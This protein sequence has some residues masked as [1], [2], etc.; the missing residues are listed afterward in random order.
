M[1]NIYMAVIAAFVLF[2][3]GNGWAADKAVSTP[4][5]VMQAVQTQIGVCKAEKAK[6]ARQC[7]ASLYGQILS[8]QFVNWQQGSAVSLRLADVGFQT[9]SSAT[10][11]FQTL[12]WQGQML[13]QEF[14]DL[15]L[16][17]NAVKRALR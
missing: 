5:P 6:V 9:R 13:N 2:F 14:T 10:P 11:E 1:K 8:R 12:L 16:A 17:Q 15:E 3:A 7:L 4:S